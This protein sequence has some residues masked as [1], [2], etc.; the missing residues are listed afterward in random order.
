M[1]RAGAKGLR[2]G[3]AGGD[4]QAGLTGSY[5]T[6]IKFMNDTVE[7]V[8]FSGTTLGQLRTGRGGGRGR[9]G[10]NTDINNKVLSDETGS[11]HRETGMTHSL[12]K[13]AL[14]H[15]LL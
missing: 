1:T 5:E 15:Q 13:L 14:L 7:Q 11:V 9:Q 6:G 10:R 4:E 3:S 8:G 2:R 12:S